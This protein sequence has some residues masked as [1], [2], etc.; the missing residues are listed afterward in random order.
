MKSSSPETADP[1]LNLSGRMSGIL[2]SMTHDD[3]NH[4][5]VTLPS[6][7]HTWRQRH[8]GQANKQ[9]TNKQ[10]NKQRASQQVQAS[11]QNNATQ[12]STRHDKTR[13]DRTRQNTKHVQ[14]RAIVIRCRS[15]LALAAPLDPLWRSCKAGKVGIAPPAP[16]ETVHFGRTICRQRQAVQALLAQVHGTSIFVD[17][18]CWHD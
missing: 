1:R 10:T 18:S 9:T 3:S 16:S 11:K 14:K 6:S 12:N 8:R 2:S 15:E 13:H 17:L 4:G 7:G 5:L